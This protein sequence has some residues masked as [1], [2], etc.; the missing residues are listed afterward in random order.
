[1]LRHNIFC[2]HYCRPQHF[3]W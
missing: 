1:M 2:C 3:R